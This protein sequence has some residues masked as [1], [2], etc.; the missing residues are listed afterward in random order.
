MCVHVLAIKLR[1]HFDFS[2]VWQENV[3][4][5][6]LYSADNISVNFLKHPSQQ[7]Y[8]HVECN[9]PSLFVS[10]KNSKSI[11]FNGNCIMRL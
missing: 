7:F 2:L 5:H 1:I 10:D 4:S 8:F 9:F 3:S 6:L 11:R